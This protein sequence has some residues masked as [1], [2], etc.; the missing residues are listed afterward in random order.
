MGMIDEFKEFAVKGNAI[1]LAVGVVLGAAFGKIVTSLVDD[2]IMP[3]IGLALG[4]VDFTD[5]F[6]NLGPGFYASLEEAKA[7]GAPTLNYGNFLQNIVDFLLVALALFL[8]VR[9]INRLRRRREEAPAAPAAPPEEV[10]LL[11]EIRDSL[12][13]RPV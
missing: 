3:P 8:I 2:I 5:L 11:R 1:D 10:A 4:G 12:Q 9:V 7:A 13:R 6:V